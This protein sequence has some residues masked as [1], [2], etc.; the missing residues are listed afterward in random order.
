MRSTQMVKA[1]VAVTLALGALALGAP[2]QAA[3][4]TAGTA[5]AVASPA[6]W[7]DTGQRFMAPT[8]CT[9]A[10]RVC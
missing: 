5:P 9:R 8:D 1:S 7:N 6:V 10:S 2:A 3:T 4:V